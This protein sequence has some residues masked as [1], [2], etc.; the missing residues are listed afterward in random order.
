MT[1]CHDQMT[2]NC[3]HMS[4]ICDQTTAGMNW[5]KQLLVIII[6]RPLVLL[7]TRF[8]YSNRIVGHDQMTIGHDQM[9]I[10]HDLMT[11]CHDQLSVGHDRMT[12]WDDQKNSQFNS[13][14]WSRPNKGCSWSNDCLSWPN[15]CWSYQMKFIMERPISFT[16]SLHLWTIRDQ[17]LW[18]FQN[19]FMASRDNN[20]TYQ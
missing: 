10:G 13:D 6:K 17:W 5:T 2:V 19:L 11:T 16:F 4:V 15:N 18:N 8:C 1:I 3:D 12:L 14:C 7:A 20:T 9:T